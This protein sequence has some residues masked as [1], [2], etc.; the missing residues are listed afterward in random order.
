MSDTTSELDGH[1]VFR[2]IGQLHDTL[3]RKLNSG[4]HVV[5]MSNG[6]FSGLHRQLLQSLS[7]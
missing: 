5:I 4:D 7:P 1:F 2:D 3:V 6:S